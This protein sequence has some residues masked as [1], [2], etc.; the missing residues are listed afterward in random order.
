MAHHKIRD[1]NGDEG[2]SVV[3]GEVVTDKV[4]SNHGA[5]APGLDGLFI[6][7]L[8]CG[9]N[10]KQKLLIDIGTIFQRTC[11]NELLMS[12]LQVR[13]LALGLATILYN[14]C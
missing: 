8:D 11:H 10:L 3:N 1:E 7:R 6:T 14:K 13:L 12:D 5:A 2:F 9:I 4:R